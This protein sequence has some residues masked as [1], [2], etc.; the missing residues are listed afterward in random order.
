MRCFIVVSLLMMS[1]PLFAESID[2]DHG[3]KARVYTPELVV[4]SL[5][6]G[7]KGAVQLLWQKS[8]KPTRYEIEVSNGQSVYSQVG[9][10]HFHHIMLYFG[11]D[12]QWR[13]REVSASKTT[14]FTAW[15]PLKV[16]KADNQELAHVSEDHKPASIKKKNQDLDEFI[17]DTGA[18]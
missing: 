11:K 15:M 10:K 12:Y 14:D 4:D 5:N 1:N 3:F 9:E 7:E 6:H 13:V 16:V 8:N 18:Q 2:S 17:L